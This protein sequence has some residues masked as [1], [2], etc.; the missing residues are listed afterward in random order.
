MASTA[1][2]GVQATARSPWARGGGRGEL[3]SRHRVGGSQR[4]G[5]P[6][7]RISSRKSTTA[8]P[9]AA[10]DGS[11]PT[12]DELPDFAKARRPLP[13]VRDVVKNPIKFASDLTDAIP[14]GATKVCVTAWGRGGKVN[15]N[16]HLRCFV[17]ALRAEAC[18][19]S[20]GKCKACKASFVRGTLRLGYVT[21]GPD[22]V[23]WLCHECSAKQLAP[24]AVRESGWAASASAR[25]TSG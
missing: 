16:Q 20:R 22:E 5:P 8:A 18:A 7:R 23:A 19:A 12:Q 15:A 4:P 9:R 24:I 11:A 25:I 14:K 6:N 10:V 2:V 1:A 21:T 3:G 13:N 17:R